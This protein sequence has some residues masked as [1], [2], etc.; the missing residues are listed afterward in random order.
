MIPALLATL[1]FALSAVFGSRAARLIGGTET[2]FWRLLIATA[3]LAVWAHGFGAGLGGEAFPMFILSGFLG[4]GV[5]DVA[6]YNALPRLGARLTSLLLQCLTTPFAAA[7]EW[8]WLGTALS[9]AESVCIAGILGGV[10]LALA[11]QAG[12][13]GGEARRARLSGLVFCAVAALGNAL[14]MVMSRKAHAIAELAGEPL[15]G[16]TAA[17]QRTLG[18]LLIAALFLLVA[19]RTHVA[20]HLTTVPE[21]DGVAML[22]EGAAIKDKWGAA[23]PWVL[24][25]GLS[26]MALGVS[27]LQWSLRTTPAAVVQAVVAITPLVIIPLARRFEGERPTRRSLVGGLIAVLAAVVLALVRH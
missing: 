13:G 4:I 11:G 24:A 1:C 21:L 27:F 19:K 26:G 6:L 8:L 15:D 17:Y 20:G 10:M 3:A 22:R 25:N 23:W 14:G 2:N 5:G 18:G 7:A 12:E 9:L 16:G